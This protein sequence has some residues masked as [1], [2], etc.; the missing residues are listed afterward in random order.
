LEDQLKSAQSWHAELRRY[1]KEFNKFTERGDKIVARYRDERGDND[2]QAKFNILWSNVRTLKPAIYSRP[3]KP[4]VSRRF[5][6]Q[7]PVARCASTIIERAL[8]YEL[9]QFGDYNSAL[10]NA[11]DDR[12]LP[13]RGVAW[14]RYEPTTET[15]DL[16]PQITEDVEV[17]GESYGGGL[18]AEEANETGEANALAGEITEPLERIVSETT[19]VDY[20]YWKD[21]AHLPAR[22]WEEVTWVARR[23][24]LSQEEVIERFGE[25][26][27]DIPLTNQT[28]KED[29]KEIT[30]KDSTS[31]KAAIW[32]IWCKSSKKVKWLAE[33]YDYI[34]DERDDPLELECFFPCPKPIYATITTGS[35]APVPDYVMYQDQAQEIDAITGRIKHL[36]ESLKVAGIYASS[37][38]A[39]SRLVKETN[40]G[41][42]IPVKD[43][44]A[45]ADKGGLKGVI[46]WI[47]LGEIIRVLSELY[48]N[49]DACKQVIYEITG[50]SDILRGASVAQETATAQQIKSQYASIRLSDMKND[51]ARFA[52]DLL[53]MKAEIMCSK[54]QP[55][56]L[57]EQSGIMATPD[58]QYVEQ[59]IAL[60]KNETLR[61]FSID[62]END[63]LVQLDEQTEK[64]SR[65]EF[66]TAVGGFLE[67]AV[68]AAQQSPDLVPLLGDM[69]MFGIR[70]FRVGR[71]MEA[72]FESALEQMKQ[73]QAI[74]AQQPPPPT[75]EQLKAQADAQAKQAELQ[76]SMQL[77]QLR[78][79]A[80]QERSAAEMQ[81][82]TEKIQLEMQLEQWKTE[83]S[84]A[85]E[86]WKAELEEQ[87]K[88]TIAAM[89]AQQTQRYGEENDGITH[90]GA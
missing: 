71:S 28:H 37:E 66:L 65:V 8:S 54:Y 51:V 41:D 1:K 62:I 25:R 75:P 19:P 85:F 87:T 33:G 7:N 20:V 13:G 14:L 67:K 90:I 52:R 56:T 81:R 18:E 34:L 68:Q 29:D 69:L 2:A 79:Q 15:I 89:N 21:F 39:I 11:V 50:I 80:E 47:P 82:E 4:E 22:T 9:T 76:Q 5:N 36:T 46:E 17:G 77:E 12:L 83:Q 30:A 48:R 26:F 35:M 24:Y 10:S 53:R 6:D 59:A 86:R 3:P 27:K 78:M 60:L 74:K 42:L 70:G 23:V 63:T 31:Q 16:E 58:A 49:R 32:E 43:W 38:E 72:N 88:I 64:Q 55:Q 45:F 84:L 40:D 61:N 44:A 57:V 73:A